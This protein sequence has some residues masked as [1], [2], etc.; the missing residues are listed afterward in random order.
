MSRMAPSLVSSSAVM[1]LAAGFPPLARGRQAPPVSLPLPVPAHYEAVPVAVQTDPCVMPTEV[2]EFT[3]QDRLLV[4]VRA[5]AASGPPE[6][7]VRLLN[8]LGHLLP[9]LPS[10]AS[11]DGA[12]QF[13][14]RFARYPRDE[15][16][17]EVKVISGSE[18]I[19]QLLPIRLAGS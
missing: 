4:R 14:L 5:F 15:Y 13:E 19:T 1:L 12:A 9:A 17:L 11:V 18:S 3:R 2:R 7:H 6:V 8:R 10:L 16:R